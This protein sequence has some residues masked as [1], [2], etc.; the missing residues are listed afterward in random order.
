[1]ANSRLKWDKAG[2]EAVNRLRAASPAEILGRINRFNRANLEA[3]SEDQIRERIGRTMDGYF[4]KTMR[5]V[6]NQMF[7]ARKNPT[8]H[9]FENSAEL[10]YPPADVVQAGRFNRAGE[11]VFYATNTMNA[12]IW[13]ARPEVGDRIT[14]AICDTV[15]PLLDVTCA[16][17]GLNRYRGRAPS[18]GGVPDLRSDAQF[19]S[20]LANEQ[21]DRKWSRVDDFLADLAVADGLERPGLY[22]ATR[23]IGKTLMGIETA[24]GLIYPSVAAGLAA[25]NLML[26]PDVADSKL[27]VGKA[28]E[29]EMVQHLEHVEGHPQSKPGYAVMRPI[30][31]SRSI[32]ADGSLVW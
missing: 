20:G 30:K 16:H 18:E 23:Q 19:I 26:E 5:L 11:P 1:M 7:R 12:A 31:H 14:V 6:T 21:L 28:L 27:R 15:G 24:E 25:F 29:F 9:S 3:L 32:K 13:E 4:T 17:I 10:W 22:M 2:Q 8:A